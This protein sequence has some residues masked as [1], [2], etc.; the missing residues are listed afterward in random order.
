MNSK[1]G[2][3]LSNISE[4]LSV[5]MADISGISHK[6]IKQNIR[7]MQNEN[8]WEINLG[9]ELMQSRINMH[10]TMEI[11]GFA[12]EEIKMMLNSICTS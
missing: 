8:N 3:I 12:D 1:M 11:P 5:D 4:E 6:L 10:G 2:Q 7:Y 9:H